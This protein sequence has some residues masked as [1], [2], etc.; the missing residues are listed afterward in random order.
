MLILLVFHSV[1]LAEDL[2]ATFSERWRKLLALQLIWDLLQGNRPV[3]GEMRGY[4]G[5]QVADFPGFLSVTLTY[6]VWV[7]F[8]K[9]TLS[10]LIAV[11]LNCFANE[12]TN[13]R[14][15]GRYIVWFPTRRWK[16]IRVRR[17]LEGD[18]YFLGKLLGNRVCPKLSDKISC[19]PS[20]YRIGIQTTGFRLAPQLPKSASR[21]V[22][23]NLMTMWRN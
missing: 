12:S 23:C 2:W 13:K 6:H 15:M 1:T 22:I 8:W 9:V 7:N 5:P 18:V 11:K 16:R 17:Q 19:C 20:E 21:Y 10:P 3:N 14:K 4:A